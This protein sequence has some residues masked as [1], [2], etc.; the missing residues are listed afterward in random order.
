MPVNWRKPILLGMLK[1][2]GGPILEELNFARSIEH[3]P[4]DE[5][6]AIQEQRLTRLILHAWENTQYYHEVLHDRRVVRNGKVNLDKF[7]DIP[8]LTKDII[9]REGD[10]LRAR[11]LPRG[12]TPYVNRSG[13]ST[14]Q[15]VEFW[16]DS[17]YNTVNIATKLYHFETLGKKPGEHEMKLWGAERDLFTDTSG[18]IVKL[19]NFLYNRSV[20][21]CRNLSEQD[22]L[23][24]V[25]HINRTR[26][27]I[28]WAYVDGAYA[29]ASYINSNGIKV[30]T[31]AAVF[32]G[33]GTI[34]PHME[35][36]IQFAF[37][38]PVINFYGS[39]EMGAVACECP[40]NAGLHIASH[41][42]V[43]ETLDQEGQPVSEEDGNLVIT[44]LANYAM[45]LIR[46]SIGDRGRLTSRACPCGRGFPLLESVSGRAMESF[47][48]S[49]N[50]LISPI[51]LITVIGT[52]FRPG[53]VKKFQLIQEDY[54][55]V[56]LKI[57]PEP[58]ARND[59]DLSASLAEVFEKINAVMGRD[60]K[61]ATEFV[62]DIPPQQSGKYLYTMSK[63]LTHGYSSQNAFSSP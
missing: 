7:N 35:E 36:E 37:D 59:A 49:N 16:Q 62:D 4:P 23:S 61:I 6:R 57:V 41:S 40:E 21:S 10:S 55:H 34:F 48:T 24:L 47:V 50:E 38:A 20:R 58:N 46:Y 43:V 5:I 28:I 2:G 63:V 15:P 1:V 18:F 30:H 27:K 60:C 51:Y 9:R 3:K 52:A 56:I 14:G 45:P 39:R 42:H 8:L 11:V 17:Y 44:S 25:K 53:L 22:M 33:G 19:K 31:P 13:G 12:R 26:P 29:L 32:C 54:K